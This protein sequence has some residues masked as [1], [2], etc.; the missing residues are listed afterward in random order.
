MYT[1]EVTTQWTTDAD[2]ANVPALAALLQAGDSC[3][4][5][6][7]QPAQNITPDPNVTVWR[8]HCSGA[9]LAAIEADVDHEVLWSEEVAEDE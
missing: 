4:D 2:G 9:T 7:G 8:V 5:V 6:S 1:A 3:E